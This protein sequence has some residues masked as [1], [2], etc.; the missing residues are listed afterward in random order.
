MESLSL[1][2][3]MSLL[4][5]GCVNGVPPGC[6]LLRASHR[7]LST[8]L[9]D[10]FPQVC[11]SLRLHSAIASH[12]THGNVSAKYIKLTRSDYPPNFPFPIRWKIYSCQF[13]MIFLSSAFGLRLRKSPA[14]F[15]FSFQECCKFH[16]RKNTSSV[17]LNL[18]LNTMC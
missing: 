13:K 8:S 1:A 5:T 7:F 17:I 10:Y 4:N 15:F 14:S 18:F 6:N 11:R 16:E 9:H 2:H 3:R 12:C